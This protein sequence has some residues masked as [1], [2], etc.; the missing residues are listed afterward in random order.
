MQKPEVK[1]SSSVKRNTD[2]N[3]RNDS[4]VSSTTAMKV[5]QDSHESGLFVKAKI[6]LLIE[7]CAKF[8]D[9]GR[10]L[11][12]R[13]V[14]N[15]SE[16]IPV[17]LMNVSG[18]SQTIFKNTVVGMTFPVK[19]IIMPETEGSVNHVM[20][21]EREEI[22][23]VKHMQRLH[24]GQDHCIT[25]L[26]STEPE[27]SP[28]RRVEDEEDWQEDP[29]ELLF[30]EEKDR[31]AGRTYRKKTSPVLPGVKRR[32]TETSETVTIDLPTNKEIE[33]EEPSNSALV[34]QKA[35]LDDQHC[36][37]CSKKSKKADAETQTD[38]NLKAGKSHQ[39][40]I[41]VTRKFQKD[42][43]TVERFEEDIWND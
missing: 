9:S 21:G 16:K 24:P 4:R 41:R 1:D 38:T 11:V 25:P 37:C 8:Q 20:P 23:L 35:P 26:E 27:K 34:V 30:E 36:S 10:A 19:E 15:S 39:K 2:S 28:T 32:N 22:V 42:G 13:S 3:K 12:A 14:V 43:E 17:R 18:P 40:I 33:I 7:P 29:G 5:D 31:E 6:P